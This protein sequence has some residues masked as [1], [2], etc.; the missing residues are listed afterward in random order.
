M[1]HTIKAITTLLLFSINFS[2][3]IPDDGP[4]PCNDRNRFEYLNEEELNTTPYFANRKPTDTITYV[5]NNT[6]TQQFIY[7]KT[8]TTY[9]IINENTNPNNLCAYNVHYQELNITYS[10]IK[11]NIVFKIALKKE[12][13]YITRITGYL[14]NYKF[15]IPLYAFKLT[16]GS[17]YIG[18]KHINNKL[19]K[20]VIFIPLKNEEISIGYVY[21]N[22]E[23]GLLQ[24]ED[25]KSNTIITL[26]P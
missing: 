4:Q 13:Q 6:D 15:E 23:Y 5:I 7:Q 20:N 26:V 9:R 24:I 21:F 12:E 10:A 1:K 3:C 19:V 17:N 14:S 2:S 22:N 8:D 25:T 18:D 11:G 16:S